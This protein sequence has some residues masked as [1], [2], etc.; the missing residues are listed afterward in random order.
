[1]SPVAPC[2]A[3]RRISFRAPSAWLRLMNVRRESY[4]NASLSPPRL[5]RARWLR[6]LLSA[7]QRESVPLE[8]DQLVST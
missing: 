5:L 8:R 1:M 2:V 6:P 7:P 3:Q 4:L